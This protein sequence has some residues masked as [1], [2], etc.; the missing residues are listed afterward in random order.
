MKKVILSLCLLMLIAFASCDKMDF[1]GKDVE[2]K[3]WKKEKD[4]KGDKA[5]CFTMIYPISFTM[6]DGSTATYSDEDA[7]NNGLKTWY[8][9]NPNATTKPTFVY[10]ADVKLKDGMVKTI[11]TETEMIKLKKWCDG[12]K[13]KCF[14]MVYP[15]SF[16]MP[17]GSTATY[18]NKDAMN[19]GLKTWYNANPNA[20]TKPTFVYPADVKLKDGIVKTINTETE[21]IKLKKWCYGK[22]KLES[23]DDVSVE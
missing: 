1:L 2:D 6:P 5:K 22:D 13:V 19:N 12:D 9:A 18:S 14:E 4:D 11:S 23:K 7:M 20:T 3:E 16:T 8:N 10:P 21:M 17:D 15:I